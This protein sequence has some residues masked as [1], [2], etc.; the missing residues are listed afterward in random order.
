VRAGVPS[1]SGAR[2]QRSV[3]ACLASI[4]EIDAGDVPVPGERHPDPWTV[5]GQWL[6]LRGLGLVPIDAP[7]SFNW[8]GPWLAMLQAADGNGTVG[9]VAFGSPPGIAWN[10]FDGPET[11]DAVRAG[12]VI[13]PAD[14][15]LWT[16]STIAAPRRAGR[17]EAIAIAAEAEAPM[18]CVE[19][20]VARSSRGL[21]GDRYFDQRGTFSNVHGRGYDLTLIEAE[22]LDALE[23]PDGRLAPQEARRNLITRGIDLN[24]LVGKPF[25]VGGVA[26]MG[27]RLCEPCAHLE[28]LTAN[29]GKPGTL[30]ALIHKGGLRADVLSDGEIQ[31]GDE[32][33]AR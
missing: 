19:R 32:I 2:M 13:A 28:R 31:V 20:A 9:A 15:A 21:E 23:L 17:V 8:P 11:F 14:I 16:P 30:R 29:A 6:A 18:T 12:Y 25:T 33:T 10:P 27:Q 3:A 1:R 26:C 4:V 5:W 22:V 24:A 7:A